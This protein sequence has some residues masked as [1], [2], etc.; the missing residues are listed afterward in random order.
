GEIGRGVVGPVVMQLA[1]ALTAALGNLEIADEDRAG[2][3]FGAT[4]QGAA[5]HGRPEVANRADVNSTHSKEDGQSDD[6]APEPGCRCGSMTRSV[7]TTVSASA[8]G[9]CGVWMTRP[10]RPCAAAVCPRACPAC[11]RSG[12]RTAGRRQLV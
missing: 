4:A 1:A 2:A 7:R 8:A 9:C 12:P 10:G 11:R 6:P 3:A 5:A